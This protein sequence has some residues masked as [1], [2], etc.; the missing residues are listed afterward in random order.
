MRLRASSGVAMCPACGFA[1]PGLD[2]CELTG[3]CVECARKKLGRICDE[4]P[5]RRR[6]DA[7]LEGLRFVKSLEP[8][9]DVFVDT[10]R[11]VVQKAERYGRVDIAVAFMKSVVGLI[12]ALEGGEPQAVF[13][14]WVNT[15]LRRDVVVKLLKTPYLLQEDFY[16]EFRW[17]CAEFKCRGLEAPLSNLLVLVLSLSLIEG[18]AD[19]S[20]YFSLV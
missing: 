10:S 11:R 14:I 7:A 4:C 19:P 12:K 6:C 5:E 15:I 20:R 9:L 18:V 8:K 1:M 16:D 2:I 3:T 13:P 17:L